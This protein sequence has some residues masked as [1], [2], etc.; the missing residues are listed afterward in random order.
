MIRSFSGGKHQRQ[1][2]CGR[3]EIH[4][5]G[6][7]MIFIGGASWEKSARSDR[8]RTHGTNCLLLTTR[9]RYGPSANPVVSPDVEIVFGLPSLST[10]LAEFASR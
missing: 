6:K 5:P 8:R 3:T 2:P 9:N 10:M 4:H 7:T 1:Q